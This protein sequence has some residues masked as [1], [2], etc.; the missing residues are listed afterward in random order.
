MAR[1]VAGDPARWPPDQLHHLDTMEIGGPEQSPELCE[2]MV[3]AG[4]RDDEVCAILGGNWLRAARDAWK[5]PTG[6]A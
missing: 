6:G 3:R 4:Y 5:T 2:R 1:V